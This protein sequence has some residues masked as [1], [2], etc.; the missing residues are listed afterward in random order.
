MSGNFGE[1]HKNIINENID[2]YMYSILTPCLCNTRFFT[3]PSHIFN[4]RN[5]YILHRHFEYRYYGDYQTEVVG[6]IEETIH[7][8]ECVKYDFYN[9]IKER[10]I[11]L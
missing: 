11:I 10:R 3:L 5:K 7:C 9:K 6:R 8:L 4:K 1:E 2:E